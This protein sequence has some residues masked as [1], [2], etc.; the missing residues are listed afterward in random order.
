[1]SYEKETHIDL[2][3]G[4]G[5]FALAADAVFP[6]IRH[7]FCDNEPF[8]QAIL[9]KHW[10]S[11]PIFG[12]IRGLT[13]DA[14]SE[15]QLQQEGCKREKRER[16]SDKHPFLLTGGFP[17]QPFSAAGRRKGTADNRY[18]WPEMHRVIRET[19]PRWVIAENVRGLTTWNE[20]MVLE[21]VCADLEMAGYEVWP[22]VIPAV[23]V[24]APHKRER[25]WIVAYADGDK[26]RRWRGASGKANGIQ[27]INR[28]E[29]RAGRTGGADDDDATD[30]ED[31]RQRGRRG[32][33]RGVQRKL[34]ASEPR[35]DEARHQDERRD[36][37]DWYETAARLCTLDDGLPDG[38]VRPKGWRNAA[39]KA[40]GNAI[41]PQVA[42]ELMIAIRDSE[43][44]YL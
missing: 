31:K 15:G 40:A 22:F 24:N 12:D 38:L 44:A 7:I 18:L 4:I 30:T 19:L 33:E 42:M 13:A 27:G 3:S 8:A 5:G 25:I 28:Q 21:A 11:A 9:K 35:R 10:P 34:V 14:I 2:F 32:E 41:V 16:S 29:V 6:G 20:G 37:S 43:D 1:M 17:C 26:H 39:L 36:W 23:A